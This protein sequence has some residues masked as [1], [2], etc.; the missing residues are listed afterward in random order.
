MM[1]VNKRRKRTTQGMQRRRFLQYAGTGVVA[2]LISPRWAASTPALGKVDRSKLSEYPSL[3]LKE[4][5]RRWNNARKFMREHK[6]DALLVLNAVNNYFTNDPQERSIVFFP[7]EGEPTAF[8]PGA[9]S[10]QQVDQLVKSEIEGQVSWVRD[11]RFG[12][13]AGP[14]LVYIIKEKKLEGSRIG[15][16]GLTRAEKHAEFDEKRVHGEK[17]S[18][19]SN[20]LAAYL[21]SSLPQANWVEL[22]DQFLPIW[23]VHS[24]EELAMCRKAA[25]GLEA[26]TEA[27]MDVCKPG[28]NLA[29]VSVAVVSTA[30]SYGLEINAPGLY[31]GPDGGR[32]TKWHA[33]GLPPPVIKQGYLVHSELGCGCGP[34]RAEV[35]IT[36]SVGEPSKEIAQLARLARE[37][38]DIGLKKLHPGIAFGEVA[39]A[40]LEP[41]KREGAWLLTPVFTSLN[42]G[43]LTSACRMGMLEKYTG[44][45]ER[46]GAEKLVG[47]PMV[48]G[49]IVLQEGM[50]FS[51]EPNAAIG[52]KYVNIGGTIICTR[53]GCEELANLAT[54]LIVVNA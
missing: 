9:G 16:F 41:T 5:D 12:R 18:W 45:K 8:L 6:V 37:A 47:H 4:R 33:R 11:W 27:F 2:G 19:E 20:P 3:S 13:G 50:T 17:Q 25:L 40:M 29:D 26:V 49:D 31:T 28:K 22:Y 35:Q 24:E 44:V 51:F 7:L 15:T 21:K 46:L 43:E 14:D 32:S 39:E 10:V 54:R 42:P 34:M 38:Y 48:G 23:L 36:V 1:T 52:R 53:T 30:L